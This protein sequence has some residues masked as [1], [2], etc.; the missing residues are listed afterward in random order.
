MTAKCDRHEDKLL[1]ILEWQANRKSSRR[2][3]ISDKALDMISFDPN[4]RIDKTRSGDGV[5]TEFAVEDHALT[6]K[7]P[8]SE[9]FF[10]NDR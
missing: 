9:G 1:R 4:T 2:R 7:L 8:P 6:I 3:I 5:V 10:W